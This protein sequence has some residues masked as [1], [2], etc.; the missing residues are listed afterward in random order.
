MLNIAAFARSKGV[1]YGWVL[2]GLGAS[3]FA[4]SSGAVYYTFGVYIGPVVEEMGWSR[5]ATSI[6][7]SLFTIING[8][9]GPFVAMLIERIGVRRAMLAG[10]V[11]VIAGLYMLSLMTHLW[12]LYALY[13]V[14]LGIGLG[15]TSYVSMTTLFNTWF[16]R[17]RS[18]A[19]GIAMAGSGLGT[20]IMAPMIRYLIE[21]IGWRDSWR[22]LAAVAFVF[23]FVPTL[24]LARDRPQDVGL[25]PERDAQSTP[26]DVKR[27]MRPYNTAVDWTARSAFRTPALW[28][29]TFMAFS[30]S[31]A[32]SMMTSHQVIHLEDVGIAPVVAASAL[33]LMVA[34][35]SAGRL[36]CGVL[37]Q[38]FQLRYV[39]AVA[40]SLQ[41]VGLLLLMFARNLPMVYA[42]VICFGPAYGTMV[43]L[44][45]SIVGAYFGRKSYAYIFGILFA[46]VSLASAGSPLLAGYVFDALG[47]YRIPFSAAA[48]IS[49]LAACAAL[50]AKPPAM[51]TG[52]SPS[53]ISAVPAR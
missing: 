43:I 1:F 40:L 42:Y 27:R 19:I 15:S 12:H 24:I 22:V 38:W 50:L 41:V 3:V 10:Q 31:F 18:L 9:T 5:G 14:L 20:V 26:G 34:T 51:R 7:F 13:G 32:L 48:T 47:S 8:G 23:A 53:D 2:V 35:S 46:I 44:F 28:L 16:T 36:A 29:I 4:V 33:G 30:N 6:A 17:R 39:A 21:V 49:A 25:E 52:G 37:G 11:L 45:P